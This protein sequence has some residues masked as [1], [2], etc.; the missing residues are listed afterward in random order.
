MYS[1]IS[2]IPHEQRR[3][4]LPPADWILI[5]APL[6]WTFPEITNAFAAEVNDV[7]PVSPETVS[8]VVYSSLQHVRCV[9]VTHEML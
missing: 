7:E 9:I 3:L 4:V 5:L 2:S 1:W 6:T 8:W